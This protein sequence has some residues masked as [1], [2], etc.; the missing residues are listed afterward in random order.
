MAAKQKEKTIQKTRADNRTIYVGYDDLTRDTD[1]IK[2]LI[3]QPETAGV[4]MKVSHAN[5]KDI[6]IYRPTTAFST[7]KEVIKEVRKFLSLIAVLQ[8]RTSLTAVRHT[9]E[10]PENTLELEEVLQCLKHQSLTSSNYP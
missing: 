5:K 4:M 7:G 9:K 10:L 2:R 8:G 1:A 6:F 3:K